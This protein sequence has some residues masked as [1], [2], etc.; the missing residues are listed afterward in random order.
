MLRHIPA[1]SEQKSLPNLLTQ[2]HPL[3]AYAGRNAAELWLVGAPLSM[4]EWRDLRFRN[5]IS[6]DTVFAGDDARRKAFNNAFAGEIA[7]SIARQSRAEALH[8]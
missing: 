7:L 2:R 3:F 8:G 4:G 5:L 1:R 6:G